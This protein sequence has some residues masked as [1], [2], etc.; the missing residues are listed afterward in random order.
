MKT[1]LQD[2]RYSLRGLLKS[3]GFTLAALLALA[4]GTGANTAIF[5]VVN[6]VLLKPLPYPEPDRIVM[7]WGRFL[8]QGVTESKL[9]GPELLDFQVKSHA[10]TQLAASYDTKYNLTGEGEPERL[11]VT[12]ASAALFD[13]LGARA[14]VGRPFNRQE[15]SPGHDTVAVLSHDFW[16]RRFGSSREVI[17]KSLTLNGHPFT[18]VG[19]MPPGFAYPSRETEVWLPLG[20]DSARPGGRFSHYL[21]LLGRLKP[22]V[23]LAAAQDE[24]AAV[25]RQIQAENQKDG[26]YPADSGWGAFVQPLRERIVGEVRPALLLLLGA[27]GFVLLIA[28]ANVANLLLARSE[29]RQR[30]IA[31]RAAIGAGRGRIFRQLMTESLCL[32]LLGGALGLVLASLGVHLL[33][34][35]NPPN[36]PRLSEASSLDGTVLLVSLSIALLTGVVFG[37]A[38]M[39][40]SLRIDLNESL[41]EGARGSTGRAGEATRRMLIVSEVGLSLILLIGAALTIES[42]LRL[43][44]VAPGFHAER[45]LTAQLT[46]SRSK[47]REG[48]QQA[49]FFTRLAEAARALPGVEAVGLVSQLPLTDDDS[50]GNITLEGR[51]LAPGEVPPEVSLRT[52][53][54]GYFA[55]M[56][57]PVAKGR[58]FAAADRADAPAVAVVDQAMARRFWPD[59]QSLGKRLKL[60]GRDSKSPWMT[61]VGVVGD[62]KHHGLNAAEQEAIYVSEAQLPQAMMSLVVRS[63]SS[64]AGLVK[65]VKRAVRTLDPDLPVARVATLESLL[66]A[67]LARPRFNLLLISIL[68]V[69]A[70][71][72]TV[73]GIYSVVSY[74][75]LQRAHEIGIRM[76]IGSDRRG[77]LT[78]IIRQ[79][80]TYTGIGIGVGLVGAVL[81]TR[82]M[83]RLLFGVSATD[84][85]VFAGVSLLLMAV[86][87]AAGYIP[88]RRAT[89]LDP[90]AVLR[91]K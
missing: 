15:D 81:L 35:L 12:V 37:L 60:G 39:F 56:R 78:L 83:S 84:V 91:S 72:L 47:Y 29:G 8:G 33:I 34:V 32:A 75:V 55:A 73:V 2:L 17:G 20:L 14:E 3:P 57:I 26:Y 9:S 80:L 27:V 65:P 85:S 41:K 51:P 52:V 88:A 63:A 90:V 50:S 44:K 59:G 7:V 64:P 53:D 76:A 46:L 6:A 71:L 61:V 82:L 5:S 22:G 16:A 54:P 68:A 28:C 31:L 43:Q 21:S 58:V 23:S 13:I 18:V 45:V 67:S 10:F 49:A 86:S 42:F 89:R 69:L 74:S 66:Q 38:P 87:A 4:L 24:M 40:H 77:V 36:V 19:V 62:V 70:L 79:V 48:P 25:A 1:L 11:P 30:E